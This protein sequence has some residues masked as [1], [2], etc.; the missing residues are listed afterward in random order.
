MTGPPLKRC[1][2]GAAALLITI[3]TD[4]HAA[5]GFPDGGIVALKV[6]GELFVRSHFSKEHDVIIAMRMGANSQVDF[7]RAGLVSTD[8]PMTVETS[9]G[10]DAI[11]GCQDDAA[12][13][14]LNGTFIGANHGWFEILEL[15][16]PTHGLGESDL[17]KPWKGESGGRFYLLKVIDQ[18]RIW[19]MPENEGD[20]EKWKFQSAL[21]GAHMT[22]EGG[23]RTMMIRTATKSQLVPACRIQQQ[24]FLVDGKASLEEGKATR[25]EFL[26]VHEVYDIINPA[27]VLKAAKEQVGRRFDLV[28]AGLDALLTNDIRYKFQAFGAC[29]V[30][31]KSTVHRS[32]DLG[33]VGFVQTRV[34]ARRPQ[35]ELRYYIP[36]TLP[37]K[38]GETAYDFR[39][40]QDF[41]VRPEQP[42]RFGTAHG[43]I[44]SPERLPHR[45]IQL[46]ER[47]GADG[48]K[49]EVGYVIGYSLLEG[50]TVPSVRAAQCTEALLI[51][52]S[53]KTYPVAIDKWVGW[54]PVGTVFEC[55]AY[56]QYFHPSAASAHATA[57]YWHRQG[58]TY[59]VH[60][61]YHK[62]VESDVLKLPDYLSGKQVSILEASAG[63]ELRS[64]ETVP[65]SGLVVSVSGNQGSIILALTDRK[66]IPA[67]ESPDSVRP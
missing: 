41:N 38:S 3:A 20:L 61:D 32:F 17:G 19:V 7:Q 11:H 33:Y 37:F 63:I 65:G 14:K 39:A 54:V 16:I 48:Q 35:D 6:G 24:E 57:C 2:G 46:L 45:F 30:R 50:L 67:T 66:V 44:E 51:H 59:V 64:G 55:L 49:T 27:A 28:G 12:P 1:L 5:E 31:H 10:L 47:N 13:W 4:G 29:T 26:E 9:R 36:G 21:P 34:M 18:D 8:S 53:A 60:A 22:E 15:S 42:L 62:P 23:G 25:C 56:R 43:N 40:T 52:T 58:D